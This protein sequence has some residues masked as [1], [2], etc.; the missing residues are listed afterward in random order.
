MAAGHD[1]YPTR[2]AFVGKPRQILTVCLFYPLMVDLIS[3][4]KTG[5]PQRRRRTG[6]MAAA[7]IMLVLIGPLFPSAKSPSA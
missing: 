3:G 1:N 7:C 5:R 4:A 6:T 2:P